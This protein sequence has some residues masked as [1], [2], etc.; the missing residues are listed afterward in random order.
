MTSPSAHFLGQYVNGVAD[1]VR[2]GMEALRDWLKAY[3]VS[4]MARLHQA[5]ER[6]EKLNQH[7]G[8]REYA[9]AKLSKYTKDVKRYADERAS[10]LKA[11]S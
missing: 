9:L 11:V 10:K 7:R 2:Q 1:E 6:F 8:R 4:D 5:A 3:G